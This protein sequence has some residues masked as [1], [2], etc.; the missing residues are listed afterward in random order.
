MDRKTVRSKAPLRPGLAGGDTD[1]SLFADLCG[2]AI[3][4]ATISLFSY[5]TFE[6]L[7]KPQVCFEAVDRN[8]RSEHGLA[9]PPDAAGSARPSP[10]SPQPHRARLLRW[11]PAA[12]SGDHTFRCT[13][14]VRSRHLV[15]ACGGSS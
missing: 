9:Y 2:E 10:G 4:N 12:G 8:E 3:L 13:R 14:R 1:V 15:N 5:A 7:E 6:I 11:H